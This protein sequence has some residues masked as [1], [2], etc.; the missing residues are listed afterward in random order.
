MATGC[1]ATARPAPVT[2][3][4][5]TQPAAAPARFAVRYEGEGLLEGHFRTPGERRPFG[6][7]LEV[8]ADGPVRRLTLTTWTEQ[9]RS[10]VEPEVTWVQPGPTASQAPTVARERVDGPARTAVE[11]D[12][13]EADWAYQL[14]SLGANGAERP[15]A[16]PSLGDV[17]ERA[18]P[19]PLVELEGR[20]APARLELAH[21]AIDLSWTASLH[22]VPV[23][24]AHA[25]E[26]LVMPPVRAAAH[27]PSPEI[28]LEQLA[29][30]IHLA[31]V[32][33]GDS[34]SLV[35]ELAD[36]LLIAEA[37]LTVELANKLVD[38][39][40]ARFP[41]KPIRHVLF[42]HYHPH[43]T[44]GLRSL[45]ATGATVH[46]P[47]GNAEHARRVAARR[48]SI[49]PDRLATTPRPGTI[50]PFSGHLVLE[51]TAGHR[52]EA[53]DIGA[54]SNHTEEYV[55][56][57]LPA[58]GLLFQGDLGW[59]VTDDGQVRAGRRAEGLLTALRERRLPLKQVAQGWPLMPGHQV[60]SGQDFEAAVAA[61]AKQ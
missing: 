1:G 17:V 2:P 12:R 43:Y 40:A 42:S 59:F 36:G 15:L 60:L 47:A 5:A 57:Y 56:V 27:A 20:A 24:T 32:P 58:A 19:G 53:F 9:D 26:P 29:P 18:V 35:V 41:G 4:P 21:H 45:L 38:V 16:H 51:D 39:L 55:V 3:P 28:Q 61:R 37:T 14:A 13:L 34:A 25:Q 22:R 48:F 52:V 30:G 6:M 50:A 23:G 31:S 7:A 11:L 10:D 49:K 54:A 33:A 46:A 8:A 44:G